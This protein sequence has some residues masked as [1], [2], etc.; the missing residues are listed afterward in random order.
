MRSINATAEPSY[1][2][3]PPRKPAIEIV[4]SVFVLHFFVDHIFNQ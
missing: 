4:S 3:Y 1:L 2:Q